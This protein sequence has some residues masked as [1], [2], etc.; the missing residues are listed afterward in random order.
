M[1]YSAYLLA[2]LQNAYK[3]RPIVSYIWVICIL[4]KKKLVYKLS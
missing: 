4:R 3:E 2:I 1:E